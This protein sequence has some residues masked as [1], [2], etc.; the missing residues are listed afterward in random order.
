MYVV[1]GN[2]LRWKNLASATVLKSSVCVVLSVPAGCIDY[3]QGGIIDKEAIL[4]TLSLRNAKKSHKFYSNVQIITDLH[5]ESNVQF[6]DFSDEDKPDERIYKAQLFSCGEAFSASMF[7]SVTSSAFYSPGIMQLL[8]SLE[9]NFLCQAIPIIDSGFFYNAQLR[10]NSIC[11]GISRTLSHSIF[12][13]KIIITSPEPNLI[14]RD[15]DLAFV[16]KE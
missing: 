16:I 12:S 2:P 7:D 1:V 15:G 11:L 4:C 13:Q 9:T 10:N 6:L 5:Q 3:K 8:E 14:L